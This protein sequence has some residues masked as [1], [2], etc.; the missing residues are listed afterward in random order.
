MNTIKQGKKRLLT[1]FI[2]GF[3]LL[4]LLLIL[5]TFSNK[6]GDSFYLPWLWLIILYGPLL[7]LLYQV[8]HSNFK[9]NIRG[10][11]IL[12]ILLVI[13]SLGVI[14]SM[15]MSTIDFRINV[16]QKSFI[17]LIPLEGFIIYLIYKNLYL[18]SK[19]GGED[20][21]PKDPIV[22]ISYNHN[23]A[24]IALKIKDALEHSKIEVI[25]DR[26]NMKAGTDIQEFIKESLKACTVTLSLV[27][28]KSLESAWVA[29]ETV[30]TIFLEAYVEDKKFIACFLDPDFFDL[31]YTLKVVDKINIQI[32]KIQNLV[33]KSHEQG[34][35]TRDLNDQKSRLIALRN[36]LDGIIGRLRESL[37]LDV[38]EDAFS[39]SMKQLV[40]SI[41]VED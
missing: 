25:M 14:L 24:E 31:G 2:V 37:C 8:K 40:E 16:M 39:K 29:K 32:E 27:S 38:R 17:F 18:P 15:G 30:D 13:A 3:V 11:T 36:N 19:A 10:I 21:L 23:D 4:F 28:N 5:Q 1:T 6:Y 41:Q 33:S 9:I 20:V 26:F 12:S 35:D 7:V 22:F 34:I